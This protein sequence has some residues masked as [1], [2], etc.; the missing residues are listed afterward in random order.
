MQHKCIQSA[1]HSHVRV[2]NFSPLVIMFSGQH[3]LIVES[4]CE[5]ERS[6][7]HYMTIDDDMDLT[8]IMQCLSY[9]A[10]C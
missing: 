1:L 3:H 5:I 6:R 9:N 8:P 7:E 4:R 2:D 10:L